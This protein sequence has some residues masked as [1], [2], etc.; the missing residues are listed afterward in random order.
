MD[1]GLPFKR[2]KTLAIWW[3]NVDRHSNVRQP[4]APVP[5]RPACHERVISRSCQAGSVCWVFIFPHIVSVCDPH[6]LSFVPCSIFQRPW[7]PRF[8]P[9]H[10]HSLPYP[11]FLSFSSRLLRYVQNL[12][13]T[14]THSLSCFSFSISFHVQVHWPPSISGTLV[15]EGLF[16]PPCTFCIFSCPISRCINSQPCLATASLI[17]ICS[18]TTCY[19]F[20]YCHVTVSCTFLGLFTCTSVYPVFAEYMVW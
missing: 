6:S 7:V 12:S 13:L 17:R 19:Q 5:R 1:L 9:H 10:H 16:C 3:T 8:R 18:I 2:G 11:V 15:S 14:T 20:I 4:K